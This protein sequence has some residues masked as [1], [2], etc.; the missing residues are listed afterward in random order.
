MMSRY[1]CQIMILLLLVV[2]SC[3]NNTSAMQMY[4]PQKLGYISSYMASTAKGVCMQGEKPIKGK[5]KF[6]NNVREYTGLGMVK[7]SQ[8]GDSLYIHYNTSE[9]YKCHARVGSENINNT[10]SVLLQSDTL[11]KICTDSNI[12][13]YVFDYGHSSTSMYTIIGTTYDGKYV[14]YIDTWELTDKY[15]GLGARKSIQF[16]QIE[17]VGDTI[18]MKYDWYHG[19][20]IEPGGEFCFKWD[21]NA[22]W[23]SVEQIAY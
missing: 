8:G 3:C 10:V 5:Y 7:Y 4:Q 6:S 13:L 19:T 21:E 18:V 1:F 22:Q 11:Y 16:K 12:V 14:K 2:L 20:Y 17:F 9:D 23:F 15:F